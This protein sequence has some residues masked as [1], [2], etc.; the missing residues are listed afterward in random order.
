MTT[1]IKTALLL[2]VA[3]AGLTACGDSTSPDNV[4]GS[5]TSLIFYV[6]D[7]GG[8]PNQAPG[9]TLDIN[10]ARD[11]TTSG[12]LHVVSTDGSPPID[13]DMAGKWTRHGD[14]VE[15]DQFADTFV[16]DMVFRI[17]QLTTAPYAL[18]GDQVFGST[19]INL[20]LVRTQ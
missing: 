10:L 20:T 1:S 19:R 13:A 9:S 15:F 8:G 18:V 16:R 3:G 17:E 6:S 4:A 7:V 2:L 5:Y 11:G 14:E 12:H